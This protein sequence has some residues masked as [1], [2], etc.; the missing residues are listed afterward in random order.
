MKALRFIFKLAPLLL[1]VG[2]IYSCDVNRQNDLEPSPGTGKVVISITDAPF[3]ADLVDEV[4]VTIDRVEL[5]IAGGE[6]TAENGDPVGEENDNDKVKDKDKDKDRKKGFDYSDF[7]CDSGF[8]VISEKSKTIDLLKLQNGI[9]EILAE[10][11]IPVGV[12]DMIRLHVVDATIVIEGNSSFPLKIPSGTSSGLKI[13]LDT[14][15]T[16]TEE[17]VSE[18][19]VDFD[20]S[21]SFI[22]KGNPHNKKGITGFMFKPVIRAVNK[23]LSGSIYGK[24]VEGD[25]TAV[26]QVLVTILQGDSTLATGLTNN[27]G[28]YEVTGIPTGSYNLKAEKEGFQTATLSNVKV[29]KKS[30]VRKDIRLVRQP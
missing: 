4:N 22:V 5:R 3:P 27:R 6:C 28:M 16:V 7:D 14:L 13:K 24:V 26:P 8:V 25:T 30:R 2:L 11:T 23:S 21:R 1:W 9:S 12:Y 10:D 20:L 19:L 18:V 29:N 15:L 17:G